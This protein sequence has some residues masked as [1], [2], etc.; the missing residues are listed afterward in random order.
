MS[1]EKEQPNNEKGEAEKFAWPPLESSPEV[2]TEYMHK[3]GLPNNYAIGEVYGFDED[4]LAFLPQPIHAT[5]ICCERRNKT[6]DKQRG[7]ESN[8]NQVQYFMKQTG[9]LDNACGIIACIHATLNSNADLELKLPSDSILGRFWKD[10]KS[11]TPMERCTALER[12]DE[13]KIIHHGF[14]SKGQSREINSDQ[15]AVK[16]H[17][18]AHV[19]QNGKLVELDG[20]KAGPHIIGDCDDLL[21]GSILEVKRK[22]EDGEI[23]EQLN[24]MTLNA[25]M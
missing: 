15:S 17:F 19:I 7:S 18:I 25:A 6:Q 13:F 22:L 1:S 24:M 12:N 3:I 4:L 11:C 10:T 16:C 14:A 23:S 2:F 8:V 21:R 20:T 5:I 9:T